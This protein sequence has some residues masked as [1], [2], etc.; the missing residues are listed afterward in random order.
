MQVLWLHVQVAGYV[1]SVSLETV[2]M[3]TLKDV[4]RQNLSA[5]P[6]EMLLNAV[7]VSVLLSD[8][9]YIVVL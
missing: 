2:T 6:Q 5:I 1:K 4:I 9:Q 8:G 7:N 3:P